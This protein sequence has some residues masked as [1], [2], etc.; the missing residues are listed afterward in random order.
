VVILLLILS[1]SAQNVMAESTIRS[2]SVHP[3]L[4]NKMVTV[5]ASMCPAVTSMST[6]RL[7]RTKKN[8]QFT[9]T[10]WTP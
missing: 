3:Y 6:T 9:Y 7:L 10:K 2:R 5:F 1:A 4:N 8:L